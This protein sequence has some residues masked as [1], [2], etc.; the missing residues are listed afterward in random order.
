MASGRVLVFSKSDPVSKLLAAVNSDELYSTIISADLDQNEMVKAD[1]IRNRIDDL[2][3]ALRSDPTPGFNPA[4]ATVCSEEHWKPQLHS[5]TDT[6]GVV[7]SGKQGM[8]PYSVVVKST[9]GPAGQAAFKFAAANPNM[10]MDKFY[11]SHPNII[12]SNYAER[13][14][15]RLAALV[16]GAVTRNL[17]TPIPIIM[18]GA[19][20]DHVVTTK[21]G[22]DVAR[23]VLAVPKYYS[24]FNQLV[25]DRYDNTSLRFPYGVIDK[26]DPNIGSEFL[27]QYG[28]LSG[29]GVLS[30]NTGAPAADGVEVAPV[31]AHQ[32]QRHKSSDANADYTN[33]VSVDRDGLRALV[34]NTYIPLD[35]SKASS[36]SSY[37][38]STSDLQRTQTPV[39]TYRPVSLVTKSA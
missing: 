18:Q 30:K 8:G 31:L 1:E 19:H 15:R 11:S 22:D 7:S 38:W 35:G 39:L 36:R 29:F 16:G 4:T 37:F 34:K 26:R 13:N 24:R 14:A 2:A 21:I 28:S 17:S 5:P 23:P 27:V 20:V 3:K 9:A 25:D 10:T 12:A 33:M 6:F 32:V